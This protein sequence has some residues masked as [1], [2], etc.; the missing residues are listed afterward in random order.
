[1][2][3]AGNEPA[4]TSGQPVLRRHRQD[5]NLPPDYALLG[6][7]RRASTSAHRIEDLGV[8]HGRPAEPPGRDQEDHAIARTA[9]QVSRGRRRASGG[10]RAPAGDRRRAPRTRPPSPCGSGRGLVLRRAERR[11]ELL[12]AALVSP[13]ASA[14]SPSRS[15]EVAR[16]APEAS[17]L[18]RAASPSATKSPATFSSTLERAPASRRAPA[19]S[20]ASAAAAPAW[21]GSSSSAR[22]SDCSSPSA[23]SAS[24]SDGTSVSKKRSTC[25]AG[26]APTNSSTTSP[27]RNAFTAGM[28]WTPYRC[29]SSWF[30]STSTFTSSTLPWRGFGGALER[31]REGAARAT[32]AGP[33]VD[34]HGHLARAVDDGL[35][36][37][38]GRD[39][40]GHAQKDR[41]SR[42]RCAR[43][44]ARVRR[45]MSKIL[46]I[47][48]SVLGG[49][50]GRVRRQEDLR[51]GLGADRRGGA[52]RPQAPRDLLGEAGAALA[53]EGAIF[54][55]TRG[56]FD[57]GARRA[58]A[59]FTGEWP[60]RRAPRAGIAERRRGRRRTAIGVK[61][62]RRG[63][64]SVAAPPQSAPGRAQ[65]TGSVSDLS[66]LLGPRHPNRSVLARK[67]SERIFGIVVLAIFPRPAPPE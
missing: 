61:S 54:R 39:V 17:S 48:F 60:G 15:S 52:A 27:S 25:A 20:G 34:H 55:A 26:I 1:M 16:G 43:N 24:A 10:T 49:L 47:P 4:G 18:A 62:G 42:L 56:A 29:A 45:R 22:R 13:A 51:A 37:V 23:A 32:P 44:A 28:P 58:F 57:H 46:F 31:G 9:E 30:A 53:L 50:A 3:K 21:P 12:Q 6:R 33:E 64:P 14:A 67:T 8:D 36:E 7:S 38:S 2:A 40:H 65:V 5:A 63:Q 66:H 35:L 19:G 41:R 11:L 59:K